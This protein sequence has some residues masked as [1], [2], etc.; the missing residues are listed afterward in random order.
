VCGRKDVVKLFLDDGYID[1][2]DKVSATSKLFEAVLSGR[3]C[4]VKTLVEAGAD[5]NQES[6]WCRTKQLPIMIAIKKQNFAIIRYLLD[7]G[8]NLPG[9]STWPGEWKY[10]HVYDVLRQA[11]M[12]QGGCSALPA[13]AK[14]R[15]MS[16]EE[17]LAL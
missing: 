12:K 8:S 5:V 9:I 2:N 16:R 3:P 7:M 11:R 13:F 1:A 17:K 6:I 10:T 15:R 14:F 4:I